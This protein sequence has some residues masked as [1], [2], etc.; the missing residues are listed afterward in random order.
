MKNLL[1][2]LAAATTFAVASMGASAASPATSTFKVTVNLT[3]T[4]SVSTPA[5][6]VLAYTSFGP[7]VNQSTNF[8]VKCT[9]TLPYTV[10]VAATSGTIAGIA[11]TVGLTPP[12]GGGVGTGLDQNYIVPV[13]AIAG[14]AGTCSAASCT[15]FNT[16]TVTVTF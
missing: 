2:T 4:C 11:Y 12:S 7:A 5:D 8:N 1:K 10:G 15:G 3:P 9:N 14:Q 13:S 6:V 16:H